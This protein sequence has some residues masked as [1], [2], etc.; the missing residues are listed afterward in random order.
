MMLCRFQQ[1]DTAGSDHD[2]A[3]PAVAVWVD[4][5]NGAVPLCQR[6]DQRAQRLVDVDP[7]LDLAW[8]RRV[9]PSQSVTQPQGA[10]IGTGAVQ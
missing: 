2:C 6:H 7:D 10:P 9:I 4:D 8:Q 1:P 5:R 3:R